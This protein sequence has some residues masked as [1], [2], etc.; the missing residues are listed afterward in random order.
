MQQLTPLDAWFI[1]ESE[2]SFQ[3]IC[4]ILVFEAAGPGLSIEELRR[5]VEQRLHLLPPLRRR[6]VE[7][8]F[9]MDEPYWIEDPDFD[10]SQHL[11]EHAL[12]EP[13]DDRQLAEL[14][15]TIAGSPLNRS[16]P[17]WELHLVHGLT[18]GRTALIKKF[19]HAAVD[20]ASGF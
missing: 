2:T 7:V 14:A 6:L 1:N 3:H 16:R 5:V 9:G 12:P 4:D 11:H 10:L 13:G 17:L 18:G 20:G 8:P 15:A 19:H